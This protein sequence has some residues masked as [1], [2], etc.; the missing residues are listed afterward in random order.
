MNTET[1]N[2]VNSI[3]PVIKS[4]VN[5][6]TT[7]FPVNFDMLWKG[8]GYARKDAALLALNNAGFLTGSDFHKTMEKSTGGRQTENYRLT[9]DAAKSFCMMAR[10][11]AGKIVRGYFLQ[12]EAELKRVLLEAPKVKSLSREEI[13]EVAFES[14]ERERRLYKSNMPGLVAHYE[15]IADGKALPPAKRTLKEIVDGFGATLELGMLSSLGRHIASVYRD[16]YHEEPAQDYEE[17]RYV[18]AY[19]HTINKCVET[20][21]RG[22]GYIK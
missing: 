9:I 1:F 17:G 16:L 4:W 8:L 14:L 21:L 7:E 5:D 15:E 19:P 22:K 18:A 12:C 10:T 20:W 11:E 3:A 6:T 2:A 13:I